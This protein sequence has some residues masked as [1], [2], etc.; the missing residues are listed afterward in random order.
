LPGGAFH[1]T[2]IEARPAVAVTPVGAFGGTGAGVVG[3]GAVG[4][5]LLGECVAVFLDPPVVVGKLADELAGLQL[6]VGL[7]ADGGDRGGDRALDLQL[8]PDV[9]AHCVLVDGELHGLAARE[10]R[11]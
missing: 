11:P 6:V 2:V 9:R 4:Q 5:E 1:D 3:G 10:H 8:L 7:V